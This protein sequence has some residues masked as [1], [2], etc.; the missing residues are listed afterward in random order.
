MMTVNSAD[1]NINTES[2]HIMIDGQSSQQYV[3]TSTPSG[4]AFTA[5]QVQHTRATVELTCHYALE[6]SNN[7]D[8]LVGGVFDSEIYFDSFVIGFNI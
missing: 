4:F 1:R 3:P 7:I 6:G 8:P 5:C 2:A